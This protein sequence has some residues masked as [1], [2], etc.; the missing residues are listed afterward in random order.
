MKVVNL[1]DDATKKLE[2]KKSLMNNV[3][4]S[5]VSWET[6]VGISRSKMRY[7]PTMNRESSNGIV[8]TVTDESLLN[9]R[10]A[11]NRRRIFYKE[12]AK[13]NVTPRHSISNEQRRYVD[14]AD[15]ISNR[16]RRIFFREM[17]RNPKLDGYVSDTSNQTI[18]LA[19]C[20]VVLC[21]CSW[22][23]GSAVSTEI[24]DYFDVDESSGS[25]PTTCT[26]VGFLIGAS[27]AAIC[28][29]TAMGREHQLIACAAILS[30][31]ANALPTCLPSNGFGLLLALRTLVGVS[32]SQIYPVSMR[33]LAS[34]VNEDRRQIVLCSLLGVVCLAVALPQFVK[35]FSSSTN[36]RHVL[37]FLSGFNLVGASGAYALLRSGKFL[38]STPSSES[39]EQSTIGYGSFVKILGQKAFLLS[40]IAKA[41]HDFELFG[42]WTRIAGYYASSYFRDET[43]QR[44]AL[45][46][47]VSIA[48]G[49][50][51]CLVSGYVARRNGGVR[52]IV[53]INAASLIAT[54][55][56]GSVLLAFPHIEVGVTVGTIHGL[57]VCAD[58]ALYSA[59]LVKL[60]RRNPKQIGVALSLQMALSTT[61]SIVSVYGVP[62]MIRSL[63]WPISMMLLG[64][65]PAISITCMFFV[66]RD[67]L[68]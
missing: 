26:Q 27:V 14:M 44:A 45:Y 24:V 65:G 63:D 55:T 56:L 54:L 3:V 34:W 8:D 61:V 15:R 62:A 37:Y 30:A 58:S 68:G 53:G 2:T 32:V 23:S 25:L 9:Y 4:G 64:M 20:V 59:L 21:L 6:H 31:I 28:N 40:T 41:G 11:Y 66:L 46:A 35:A 39:T 67:D 50:I 10:S 42:Y 1:F 22:L 38:R 33:V 12:K 17:K 16:M 48:T 49:A 19:A 47:G 18:A 13:G 29:F 57:V 5:S 60:Y 7:F 36:W 51:G 52:T 43:S